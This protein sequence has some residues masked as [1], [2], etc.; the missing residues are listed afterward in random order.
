M[1]SVIIAV[2]GSSKSSL[3]HYEDTILHEIDFLS[4]PYKILLGSELETLRGLFPSG[5]A[6]FWG[7]KPGIRNDKWFNKLNPGD[8]AIF[9]GGNRL[10]SASTVVHKFDNSELAVSLWGENNSETW[11]HMYALDDSQE[12]GVSYDQAFDLIKPYGKF[13]TQGTNVF[14]DSRAEILV[15][16]FYTNRSRALEEIEVEKYQYL[17]ENGTLDKEV[18]TTARVEQP[19]LKKKLFG[20]SSSQ[21][22]ALC[23]R[24]L[25]VEILRAA[26]IRK[27]S[28]CSIE[29]K[30]DFDNIVMSACILGC[31]ALYEDGWAR[32]D[33]D[34][35][36]LE[37]KGRGRLTP[38][39]NEFIK[40]IIGRKC[41][42]HSSGSSA[43]FLWHYNRN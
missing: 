10:K 22:C 11:T 23:G 41:S 30:L 42:A 17:L 25:P 20:N 32:V 19:F 36:I 35:S 1:A 27:R 12:I 9:T 14:D 3:R 18:T 40:Q 33:S 37:G 39:L 29:E 13:N 16:A 43:Y 31:D 2:V 5:R 6:R 4:E 7:M 8:V 21:E 24:I 26:H 34:G 38:D 28:F 15:S